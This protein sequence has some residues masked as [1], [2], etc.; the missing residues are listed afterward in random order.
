M[1]LGTLHDW[2]TE[3][4]KNQLSWNKKKKIIKIKEFTKF[5]D[6]DKIAS[7]RSERQC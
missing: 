5:V 1:Y 6:Y 7:D 4:K 2:S 3:K